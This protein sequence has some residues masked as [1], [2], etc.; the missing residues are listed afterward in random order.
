[1][2]Q[3]PGEEM[4]VE[5]VHVLNSVTY[6]ES[7]MEVKQKVDVSERA[8]KIEQGDALV[9]EVSELN[10]EVHRNRGR[11]YS[12]FRTHYHNQLFG[13]SPL[14][15]GTFQIKPHQDFS[16]GFGR[17]GLG[18]ELFHT[19]ARCIQEELWT[20]RIRGGADNQP[21]RR[22][23]SADMGTESE[24]RFRIARKVQNNDIRNNFP[25]FGKLVYG[26]H[27]LLD[28]THQ[29]CLLQTGQQVC[30]AARIG[31]DNS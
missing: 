6:T 10:C 26:N 20:R 16:Q 11:A 4:A 14:C 3:E 30:G 21:Y 29:T 25:N 8:S 19:T 22:P 18:N 27:P 31:A 5:T 2:C 7:R 1:M 17:R 9:G 28:G 13:S 24:V 12:P 15:R 23:Q